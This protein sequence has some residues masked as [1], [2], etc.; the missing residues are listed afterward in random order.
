MQNTVGSRFKKIRK[1][2]NLSQ[3]ELA[4]NLN[5]TKQAISNIENSKSMPSIV[6]MSKLATKYNINLNYLIADSG[7][8]YIS[9]DE[10]YK[11][12]RNTLLEEVDEFLKARGI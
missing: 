1:I 6:S 4:K 2:L 5:I 10:N 9:K 12:L 8:I 11:S 7:E 3:E